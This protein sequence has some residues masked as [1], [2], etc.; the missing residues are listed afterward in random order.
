MRRI[1]VSGL[2]GL[3]LLSGCVSRCGCDKPTP[4]AKVYTH[5]YGQVLTEQEW[6]DKGGYGSITTRLNDGVSRTE[7]YEQGVLHGDTTETFP[8]NQAIALRQSYERGQ[9][10]KEVSFSPGGSPLQ[11]TEWLGDQRIATT[12]YP[13][14]SPMSVE[15]FE[16]DRLISGEYF[17]REH[18]LEAQVLEGKGYRICRDLQGKVTAQEEIH[19]GEVCLR[20]EFYESGSPSKV[21]PLFRG[22]IHGLVASYL[23]DGQ[24]LSTEQYQ[25][26][27]KH[28]LTTLFLNGERAQEV[29]FLLGKKEG[30]EKHYEDGHHVVRT[31][32]WRENLRHGPSETLLPEAHT[33]EYWYRDELVPKLTYERQVSKERPRRPH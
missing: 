5:K 4:L 12:W 22:A 2:S 29:P 30:L 8:F 13:D 31:V 11:Q 18:E 32:S 1:L 25:F 20:T 19:G 10:V 15:T 3:I 27:K 23:P 33:I 24:P 6:R 14:G 16:Q 17:N 9:K 28:G 7:N 21:T 26:G